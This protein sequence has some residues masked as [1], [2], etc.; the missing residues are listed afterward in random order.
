MDVEKMA[1]RFARKPQSKDRNRDL[2][3]RG[4]TNKRIEQSKEKVDN[5]VQNV[6]RRNRWLEA[7][8]RHNYIQEY[9]RIRG[10][11]SVLNKDRNAIG[12]QNL[13]DRMAHLRSM[14]Q[15]SLEEHKHPIYIK[16]EMEIKEPTRRRR[17]S[18]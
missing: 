7:S 4:I 8:K 3:I 18:L 5:H 17:P 1:V 2:G 12:I 11:L 6:E 15:A 9:D 13:K 14:A 10:T 16:A